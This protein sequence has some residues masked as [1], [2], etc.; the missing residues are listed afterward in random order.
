MKKRSENRKARE[1]RK[2]REKRI[3]TGE[4][5]RKRGVERDS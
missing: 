1:E 2:E 3:Y 4:K 5:E